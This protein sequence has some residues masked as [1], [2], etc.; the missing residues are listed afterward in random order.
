MWLVWFPVNQQWA[1][2]FGT[3]P[4]SGTP[5]RLYP[6]GKATRLFYPALCGAIA[7]ANKC[8]LV[9]HITACPNG[10]GPTGGPHPVTAMQPATAQI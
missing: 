10:G 3:T 7:T 2:V 1:F 5:C 8:G 4:Q 9:V 6:N